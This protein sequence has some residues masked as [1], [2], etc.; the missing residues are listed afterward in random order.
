MEFNG[1]SERNLIM[2]NFVILEQKWYGVPLTLNLLSGFLLILHNIREQE[3]HE[4][5]I[6]CFLRKNLIWGNMI[7]GHFLMFLTGCGQN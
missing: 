6:S 2:G 1:F 3:V 5:F 7:L 4:N